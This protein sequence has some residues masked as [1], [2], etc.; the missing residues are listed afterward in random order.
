MC[1]ETS[2]KAGVDAKVEK[3]SDRSIRQSSSMRGRCKESSPLSEQIQAA[4]KD[5][6]VTVDGLKMINPRLV[7]STNAAVE[8]GRLGLVLTPT[9]D[10]EKSLGS[11]YTTSFVSRIQNWNGC[12]NR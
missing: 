1:L 11:A 8:F 4:L 12:D 5:E 3:N 6:K 9:S 7:M 2:P 10:V